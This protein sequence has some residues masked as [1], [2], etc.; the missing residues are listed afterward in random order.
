MYPGLRE[1]A[2][3]FREPRNATTGARVSQLVFVSCGLLGVLNRCFHGE[4]R[5]EGRPSDTAETF[6]LPKSLTRSR[7]SLRSVH[8]LL[9]QNNVRLTPA[10]FSSCP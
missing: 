6:P 9:I 4:S 3:P 1:G 8:S 2:S 5:E 10:K 7:I